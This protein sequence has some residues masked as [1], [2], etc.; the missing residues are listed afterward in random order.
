MTGSGVD[1]VEPQTA[2]IAAYIRNIRY[3][4]A[5]VYSVV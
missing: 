4:T 1:K 5:I 2:Y 3:Y